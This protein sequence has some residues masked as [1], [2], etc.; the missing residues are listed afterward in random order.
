MRIGK[1]HSKEKEKVCP[2][3]RKSQREA[4][5][6]RKKRYKRKKS[7]AED[8]TR[9]ECGRGLLYIR[10]A[11]RRRSIL[12]VS[13]KVIAKKRKKSVR[14]DEYKAQSRKSQREATHLRKKRYKRKKSSAEDGTRRECGRGLL[15]IRHAERRGSILAVSAKGI[16]KR[17]KKSVRRDE[18][19]AQS[20]KSQREVAHLRKNKV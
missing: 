18:Y 14:K 3:S 8:G 13:A 12:A 19:R 7:S 10:H 5:H 1:G 9:R 15:N 6:L 17:K 4:T 2:Q 20:R 16:A 11:E